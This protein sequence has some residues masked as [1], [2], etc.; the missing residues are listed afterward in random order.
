MISL[1]HGTLVEATPSVAIVDVNGIGF[2]LGISGIT[3][4]SLPAVG[5]EA[6][7]YTRMI[8]RED[9]CTLFGFSSKEERTMFDKLVAVS[10]VGA[11]LALAVLS[12]YSVSQLYALVMAEDDKGMAK[13]SGV[14]K[15]TAQRLILELKGAFSKD[16]TLAG[17]AAA[18]SVPLPLD[19]AAPAAVS[20]MEDANAAL[21]AMG[22]TPAEVTLA[23]AG[24]DGRDMRVEDLLSAALKRLGMDA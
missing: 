23:L 20:P 12:T 7:L 17:S 10:G 14:G 8:V 1:I 3:A 9:S 15:K 19:V 5:R 11:K 18:D 21:L 13:V 4:A 22:F 6:R 24:Y 2:E 16:R